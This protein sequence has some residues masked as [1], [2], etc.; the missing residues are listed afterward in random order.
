MTTWRHKLDSAKLS[1]CKHGRN[2]WQLQVLWPLI[3]WFVMK[4]CSNYILWILDIVLFAFEQVED[5]FL[6]SGEEEDDREEEDPG[7]TMADI[8]MVSYWKFWCLLTLLIVRFEQFKICQNP[9]NI[10]FYMVL[11]KVV[12]LQQYSRCRQFVGTALFTL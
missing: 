6:S 8:C 3:Q 11:C 7:N 9:Y 4:W 12:F 2:E 10:L 1:G 5:V